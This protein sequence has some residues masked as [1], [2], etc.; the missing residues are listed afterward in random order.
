MAPRFAI[1]P[2]CCAS[3]APRPRFRATAP[4]RSSSSPGRREVGIL[5]IEQVGNYAIRIRFDDLHDTG[6]YTW[7]YL[8]ELGVNGDDVWKSYLD[9]LAAQGLS[10]D[11]RG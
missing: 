2:S 7:P 5:D 3:R 8:Y 10:R 1:R 11:P 9:A 4:A 6:I